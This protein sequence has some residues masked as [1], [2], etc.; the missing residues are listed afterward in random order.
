[1]THW[2]AMHETLASNRAD[3]EVLPAGGGWLLA[4]FGGDTAADAEARANAAMRD[5]EASAQ[6]HRSRSMRVCRAGE[7]EQ[8]WRVR[9][10]ALAVAARVSDERPTWEGWEDSAVPPERLGEYLRALR[11]LLQSYSYHG[12]FYGHFGQGC[13]HTRID[14]DL[15]TAEGVQTFRR[16]VTEAADL[17]SS[18]GGSISG[19]HGDGQARGELLGHMFSAGMLDVFREFKHLWDPAGR[20]NPGKLIDARPLDADLRLGAAYHP[21][22]LETHFRFPRD[23]R[24]FSTSTLR[25]VGVGAC[26]QLD[27][28][29]MCPSFMVTREEQHSTRGRARLLF[30]MLE[31]NPLDGPWHDDHVKGALDLCLACKGCKKDCPAS[32]DMA[33]YKAEFLS[34]YY[35][36]RRRPRHAYAFGRINQWAQLGS[37]VP[38]LINLVGR[39]PGLRTLAKWT[40]GMSQQRAIPAF[41]RRTF[42][43]WFDARQPPP[44]RRGPKV[45][46]WPDTFTNHF[47]PDVAKAAVRVLEHAGFN[48]EL[49]PAGLCCGRP[50]YDYG[51]LDAARQQLVDIMQRLRSAIEA[52]VPIVGLEPSCIAVFRDELLNLFPDDA[53][54]RRLARQT[55]LVTEFL[56]SQAGTFAWPA[57][58]RSALVHVHCHHKA[59]LDADADVDVIRRLGVKARV[60]DSGCC[61]MAG[62]FGFE[63]DHYDIS[64]RIG[65]RVLLPEVRHAAPDTLIV[66]DGFSCRE[67]ILQVAGR[68]AW[69]PVEVVSM[70]IDA[71][72]R[73]GPLESGRQTG[74]LH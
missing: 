32:V 46:L 1:M 42:R 47:C 4:E 17:V 36:G 5:L 72:E 29:T 65:E 20:M 56:S 43:Q 16:F 8:I 13:V 49:P 52:G 19:E 35:E 51:L 28:G 11:G 50:L 34:H 15:F 37:A 12:N 7:A 27:H 31:A 60:L 62:S 3:P 18:L 57:L 26:R 6:P 21:P 39:T 38:S 64:V 69:H 48:V 54:A 61:G 67:Q 70:A 74:S 55:L 44:A 73:P 23:R 24:Q 59:V 41:A 53:L 14:F 22:A 10:S 58:D 66:A 33:T 25:C 68:R 63:R 9:E 71:V 30:E 2:C 40:A 45:L